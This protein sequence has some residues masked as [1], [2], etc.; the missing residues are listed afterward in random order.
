MSP[1]LPKHLTVS[2]IQSY[3]LYNPN[4]GQVH[5]I[6]VVGAIRQ[7]RAVRLSDY[8]FG[9]L[10]MAVE[11]KLLTKTEVADEMRVD[12]LPHLKMRSIRTSV[13][14]PFL[15]PDGLPLAFDGTVL[16]GGDAVGVTTSSDLT[17]ETLGTHNN[18]Q[19][20][21]SRLLYTGGA[22]LDDAAKKALRVYTKSKP[23][24]APQPSNSASST[25]TN[26]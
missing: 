21:L 8:A 15:G 22:P 9:V 19:V 4:P 1:A 10:V 23:K 5:I 16:C 3:P 7:N 26:P 25:P 11:E 14:Q 18:Y 24:S 12:F 13:G 6:E 2:V 17:F 20:W